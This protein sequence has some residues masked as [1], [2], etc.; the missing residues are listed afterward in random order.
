MKKLFTR[1][2]IALAVII[3][4]FVSFVLLTWDKDFD[5]PLPEIKASTDSA[6]IARGKYLVY[7]PAHCATC[8]TP[9]DKY[10][11][12]EAGAELPLSGG[13]E[14]VIPP[15]T[16]RAPNITPDMETGIGKMTDAQ[17]ARAFRY[18][19]KHN[20]K[21]LFPFMPYHEMTDEDLTAIISFLR[22]QPPV[23]NE[24]KPT[25]LT[26]LGKMLM[27][28]GAMKPEQPKTTPAKAIAVDTTVE[29]GSYLANTVAN[30]VGCHTERDLKTGKFTGPKLAGGFKMPPDPFTQGYSF[31]SPNLTPHK[32]TGRIAQWDQ[33]AFVNR[34]RSGRIVEQSP[35]PWGAFSRM[36]DVE[37]IAIYKYLNSIDPVE[38]TIAKTTFAPGEAF[39]E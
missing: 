32:G 29:Y 35:M 34:F 19:V 22:S 31:I 7:G 25:E 39:P 1:V 26:F 14:L 10:K 17:L 21:V 9:M 16:M 12:V 4:G 27:A 8:H 36:N 11:E 5:A 37:L 13:W 23:K 28:L 38:N 33:A 18:S 20:N 6:M 15:G 2:L 24:L 3:G 30:C